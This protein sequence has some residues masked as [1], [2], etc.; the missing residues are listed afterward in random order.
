MNDEPVT[1]QLSRSQAL[2]LFDW[3]SRNDRPLPVSDPSEET[4]LWLL[5]GLLEKTL[6]EPLQPDYLEV[7]A[8]AR[9]TVN[10]GG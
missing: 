3:L 1:L 8:R 10:E 6:V 2:V 9:K 4:V 5:E 7:V